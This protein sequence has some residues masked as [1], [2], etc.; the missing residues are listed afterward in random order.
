[1]ATSLEKLKYVVLA[2]ELAHYVLHFP[3]LVL[4]R[5]VEETAW[6]VP[7]VE[8]YFQQLVAENPST[9]QS[10]EDQADELASFLLIPSWVYP[11]RR[12]TDRMLEGGVSPSPQEMIWRFLQ[13]LF[14]ED[15]FSDTTWRNL[16]EIKRRARPDTLRFGNVG[17]PAPSNLF[18][19]MFQAAL[20]IEKNGIGEAA[21]SNPASVLLEKMGK[22]ASKIEALPVED[23]RKRVRKLLSSPGGLNK[24]DDV[25]RDLAE[26]LGAFGREIIPPLV[27]DGTGLFPRVPLVPA[28]HNLEG[29]VEADWKLKTNPSGSPAGTVTEWRQW[30]KD[31]GLVLYRLE[32]WQKGALKKL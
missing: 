14:P 11:I 21:T 29:D 16:D 13:P 22:L 1:L 3:L 9:M 2:H 24:C 23:A 10:I 4:L 6:N 30:K 32:S 18:E 26:G 25:A 28:I 7:E 20:R 15:C 19:R 12:L 5:Y 27:G 8:S 17:S 31:H